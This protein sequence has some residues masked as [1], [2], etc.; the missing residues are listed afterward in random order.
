MLAASAV[1]VG[2]LGLLVVGGEALIRG[3][4]QLERL[5]GLSSS[6]IAI[7]MVAAG[8]SL[9]ELAVSALAA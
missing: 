8:T 9:P 1:L 3:A 4:L 7:T 2:G 5:L 6:V